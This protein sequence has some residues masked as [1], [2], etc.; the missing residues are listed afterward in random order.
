MRSTHLR[1]SWDFEIDIVPFAEMGHVALQEWV[2]SV[3]PVIVACSANV[4]LPVYPCIYET[5]VCYL[6]LV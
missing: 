6:L 1:Y 3:R 2:M 5:L 4:A